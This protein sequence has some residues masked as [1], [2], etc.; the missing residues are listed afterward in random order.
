MNQRG[1]KFFLDPNIAPDYFYKEIFE[2]HLSKENELNV[3]LKDAMRVLVGM[4]AGAIQY[5]FDSYIEHGRP[6]S[7]YFTGLKFSRGSLQGKYPRLFSEYLQNQG[8]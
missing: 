8:R 6:Q 2:S 3:D 7:G 5:A 4:D 1:Q